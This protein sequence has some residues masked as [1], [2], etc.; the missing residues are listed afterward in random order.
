MAQ[1]ST[2]TLREFDQVKDMDFEST[3]LGARKMDGV[4]ILIS[5]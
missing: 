2:D 4:L 3:D 1:F 5:Y